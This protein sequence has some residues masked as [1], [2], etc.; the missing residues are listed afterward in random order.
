MLPAFDP[1]HREGQLCKSEEYKRQYEKSAL[2]SIN[3]LHKESIAAFAELIRFLH[4]STDGNDLPRSPAM[5]AMAMALTYW[6]IVNC[7]T[8]F[9]DSF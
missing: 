2:G 9:T 7:C 5:S 8:R 4:A 3:L 6:K 1:P